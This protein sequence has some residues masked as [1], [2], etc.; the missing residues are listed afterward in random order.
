[1]PTAD[2][3]RARLM[4]TSPWAAFRADVRGLTR[5]WTTLEGAGDGGGLGGARTAG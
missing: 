4:R 3:S 2:T 5:S 1:M